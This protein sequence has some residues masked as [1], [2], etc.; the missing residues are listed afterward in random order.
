MPSP[1]LPHAYPLLAQLL[2]VARAE[3]P[4]CL[5]HCL[6]TSF[7]GQTNDTI[8]F[9]DT[10]TAAASGM[11]LPEGASACKVRLALH[12]LCKL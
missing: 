9:V 10:R 12:L 8:L 3:L 6:L 11:Q 5:H 1:S 4:W 7:K 2:S